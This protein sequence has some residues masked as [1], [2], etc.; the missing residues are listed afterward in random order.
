MIRGALITRGLRWTLGVLCIGGILACSGELGHRA[1]ELFPFLRMSRPELSYAPVDCEEDYERPSE[2]RGCVAE[3][4]S[5]GDEI[6][7]TNRGG[8]SR[9]GDQFYMRGQLTPF[10][11]DY[12]ASEE[13]VY[14]LELD[15]QTHAELTLISPCADLDLAAFAY[16][17]GFKSC[18]KIGR[19]LIETEFSSNETAIDQIIL[20]TTQLRGKAKTRK[21]L[22]IV[23]GKGEEGGS[24]G[25]EGNY[26]L[27][28]K[29]NQR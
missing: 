7:S 25:Q 27:E 4:I 2:P 9:F 12:D 23:D 14:E 11:H 1:A 21:Y 8:S 28:V 22:V 18:P 15:P 16:E 20:E 5:C 26:R 3:K 17:D 13:V 10:G 19:S 6:E 24:D 29:C